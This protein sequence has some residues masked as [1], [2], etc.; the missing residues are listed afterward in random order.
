MDQIERRD[1]PPHDDRPPVA[2]EQ[3]APQMQ[4]G[5]QDRA[6]GNQ[7]LVDILT[8]LDNL[9]NIARTAGNLSISPP[10]IQFIIGCVFQLLALAVAVSFGIYAV[11][12]VRIANQANGF[13]IQALEEARLANQI[14][15]LSICASINQNVSRPTSFISEPTLHNPILPY[16]ARCRC[17]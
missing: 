13:A 16:F 4:D 6:E 17:K 3:L 2:P 8:Q 1:E 5:V 10:L 14:A 11:K 12:S 15:M 7:Y 9:V